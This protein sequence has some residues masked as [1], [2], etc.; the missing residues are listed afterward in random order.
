MIS[1]FK[2]GF[3]AVEL[4]ITIAVGGL[5]IIALS[6]IYGVVRNDSTEIRDRANASNIAYA[7]ARTTLASKAKNTACVP[8]EPSATL[9]TTHT[10]P[11]PAGISV[12]VT[13]QSAYIHKVTV[14][15]TYDSPEKKVV[16]AIWQY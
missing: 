6:Q 4:V 5:L 3:T 7:Q 8:S 16:H 1:K 15:V 13:C 14:T 12:S 10:L 11:L 9:P 2:Q